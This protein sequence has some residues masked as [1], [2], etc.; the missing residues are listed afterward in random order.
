MVRQKPA[1]LPFPSSNLGATYFL[2][3]LF[4]SVLYLIATPI[5]NLEDISYRAVRILGQ[6]H[7]VLCEDTRHSQVLLQH[8]HIQTSLL[9][10]HRFNE[11]QREEEILMRLRCGEQ[12]ALISDAGTPG[13]CDPGE[14][15]IQRCVTE[16]IPITVLP[17]PS[18]PLAALILSGFESLTPFQFV[19]FA[20]RAEKE[21]ERAI[22]SW[23]RYAGHTLAFESP[24]RLLTTLK[25]IARQQP[26]RRLAVARELT[27][28]HEEVLRGTATELVQICMDRSI[29]GECVLVISSD[30][31]AVL[32]QQHWEHLSAEEHVQLLEETYKLPH[33]EAIR[34]AAS[35]RGLPKRSLYNSLHQSPTTDI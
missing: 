2:T 4:E 15:L 30:Q 27:K 13:L 33:K 17:G 19:G 35:Q 29:R 9:S 8:Y 28:L 23:L 32:E 22:N 10:L 16:N 26:N 31:E 3:Q 18:A 24:Q 34:L 20:P 6:C 25:E 14:R 7:L 1:K 12:I 11:A 5:G 21:R